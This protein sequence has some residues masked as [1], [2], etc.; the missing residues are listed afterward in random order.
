MTDDT[1]IG[2]PSARFPATRHSAVLAAQ[3]ADLME[4]ERGLAILVETYWKPAYK[5][6]RTRYR[7]SNEDAKDLT[8]SFFTRALEKDFFDR[9][10]PEKG[11][12][13]TYLRTCLDR[14]VSNEKK[15]A[16]RIKRSPGTPALPV[17]FESAEGE[18]HREPPADNQTMEQY[19]HNEFARSLFGLAVEKLREECAL[20]GK[21]LPF[22]LFERYELDRDP[23]EKL[24]YEKLAQ[25]FHI[26]TTQVTNFLAF[27][28]REFRRIVLE[29]LRE[30]TASDREFRE[31]ARG[32]LG[33]SE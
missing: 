26:P 11:S 9:Y 32:L 29:K 1:A 15:A 2:G 6:L 12:F 18:L 5:Y 27:A 19:F 24:T 21:D 17:D 10:D 33:V 14:F 30:I 28:R 20:R 25:D 4:R 13:R 8:Q 3:S 23:Q 7:E 16:A 22:Q 31:E